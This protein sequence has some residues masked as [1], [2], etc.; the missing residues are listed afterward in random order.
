MEATIFDLAEVSEDN[1]VPML[2]RKKVVGEQMLMAHVTLQKGC[3]VDV[4]QHESEQIAV[5]LSG[6]VLW[7]IGSI[8][9][10]EITEREV[11]GGSVVL[12]PSQV[13]HGVTALEDTVI[14]DFLSPPGA[15]GVDRQKGN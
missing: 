3:T 9:S 14:I 8:G 4:H 13:P 2:F 5:V 10:S 7:R 15:M 1:P 11:F 12:L 6:R